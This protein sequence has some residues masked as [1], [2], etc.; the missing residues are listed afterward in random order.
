MRHAYVGVWL[1]AATAGAQTVARAYSYSN[2][3]YLA[4][5]GRH[6][7]LAIFRSR[8]RVKGTA[9][10]CIAD[11]RMC[12]GRCGFI[13]TP[14]TAGRFVQPENTVCGATL[15]LDFRAGALFVQAKPRRDGTCCRATLIF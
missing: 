10:S 4:D 2:M 11:V 5:A 6:C 9:E 15:T 14:S 7:G 12:K 8:R 3:K 13:S 1:L